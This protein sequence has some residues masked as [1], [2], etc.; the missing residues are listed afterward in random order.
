MRI[1]RRRGAVAALVLLAVGLLAACRGP[2]APAAPG[3]A[4]PAASPEAGVA[5]LPVPALD[6]PPE[7]LRMVYPAATFTHGHMAV[8]QAAGYYAEQGID[9]DLQYMTGA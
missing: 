8:A 3:N 5:A 2:A 9:L 7:R 6:A 1:A 4:P